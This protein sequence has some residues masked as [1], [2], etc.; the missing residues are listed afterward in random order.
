MSN[1][2]L[3]V[4]KQGLGVYLSHLDLIHTLERAFNR[5]G[6]SIRHTQGFN[7]HPYLSFCMP[8]SLG[9]ESVCEILDFGM[10]REMDLSALPERLNN[11][12]PQGI[13][14]LE[15]YE[16][17]RKTRELTW[18]AL[19]GTLIYDQGVGD[20]KEQIVRL[21][22]APELVITR[23]TKRGEG[24]F[25]VIPWLRG[26]TVEQLSDTEL[27]LNAVVH[28]QEPGL[29]PTHLLAALGLEPG[30]APDHSRFCRREVY[31]AD[32]NVFR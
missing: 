2:R 24:P 15:A 21:F 31:D 27:M 5:A 11:A 8:L 1:T 12:L 23:R 4:A 17:E 26:V 10:E 19:S 25:D 18:L 14:V 22:S 3:L 28:A 20:R 32:M 29:G 9:V 6:I 13:C 30:L 16:S 7:P